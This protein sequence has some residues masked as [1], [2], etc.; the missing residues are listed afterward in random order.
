MDEPRTCYTE[1]SK[2]EREKQISYISGYIWNLEGWYWQTYLQGSSEDADMENR[3]VDTAGKERVGRTERLAWKHIHYH[4]ET[5][6]PGEMAGTQGAQIKCS[7]T[8]QRG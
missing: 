4:M 5:R 3:L 7:V 8:I 6:W 1:R 2:S